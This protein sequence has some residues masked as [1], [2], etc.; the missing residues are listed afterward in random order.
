MAVGGKEE[1]RA[2][3]EDVAVVYKTKLVQFLGRS[4][5]IILQN[6]N[7]PCPLLAICNVLLLRNIISLSPETTE[8]SLQR[9]LSL[10]AERLLDANSSSENKDSG[11]VQNQ[12]QN[13]ADAIDLLPRLATGID[14]NV[15][16]RHIHDFEFTRECAIFDL[17]DIGLVHGW[18]IDPQDE[19]TAR[20]IGSSSYNTLQE[21]LVALNERKTHELNTRVIEEDSVDFAAATTA[22]LGV[23]SPCLSRGKSFED[24]PVS[25]PRGQRGR[26]GD[27]EEVEELKKVLS[28]SKSGLVDVTPS[29]IK[30]ISESA[31]LHP[32]VRFDKPACESSSDPSEH[33]PQDA[34]QVGFVSEELQGNGKTTVESESEVSAVYSNILNDSI[35]KMLEKTYTEQSLMDRTGGDNAKSEDFKSGELTKV[36]DLDPQFLF[37]KTSSSFPEM[38]NKF[39]MDESCKEEVM[40]KSP[41]Q[42]SIIDSACGKPTEGLQ[43]Q[44]SS[45]CN[46]ALSQ[47]GLPLSDNKREPIDSSED[48]SSSLEGSE[49]IYEGEE[50]ILADTVLPMYENREPLYEGEVALAQQADKQAVLQGNGMASKDVTLLQ[51]WEEPLGTADR[52]AQ[53]AGALIDHFLRSNA[54]QLTVY[55]L[56]CLQEGLKERELC[57]FFR[58]NHFSTMFKLNG[59]IYLL[60]TDQGYMNQPDLVWEK[61]N[62]V[63]GDTVFMTGKFKEFKAEEQVNPGWNQNH[64]AASTADYIASVTSTQQLDSALNSDLQLA[65]ALQQQEFQQQQQQE[66]HM[67][68][69]RQRVTHPSVAASS[70]M[71]T[72]P[73]AP[74]ASTS[75]SK[76]EARSKDKCV[77]M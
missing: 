57:V 39:S 61:L 48:V 30:D 9:L 28:I 58:N 10:V 46:N 60:A 17:L 77:V 68:Q 41:C 12:Q 25:T 65:I 29:D 44:E 73:E 56:F 36:K 31:T 62:E 64:A 51:E 71:V 20:V 13:I 75:S 50:C 72:G 21:K 23:P 8:I 32:F 6:D 55:G 24:S 42:E 22:A 19:D 33:H 63:H 43:E 59:D 3:E 70:K 67:Q 5:P 2:E 53:T 27:V 4:I 54:S 52:E 37:V 76:Q 26:K 35:D 69:Q 47:W 38:H 11:Y 74:R 14:V 49:P 7:G 1:E 18:I 15:R 40:V 66:K 34:E 16:F 45:V